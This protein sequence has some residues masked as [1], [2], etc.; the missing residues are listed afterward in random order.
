MSTERRKQAHAA[1]FA[2]VLALLIMLVIPLLKNSPIPSVLLGLAKSA[3]WST[4]YDRVN[5]LSLRLPPDWT[6]VDERLGL[7]EHD[8][9][10][11]IR[12]RCASLRVDRFGSAS[13]LAWFNPQGAF[14]FHTEGRWPDVMLNSADAYVGL[15]AGRAYDYLRYNNYCEGVVGGCPLLTRTYLFRHGDSLFVI[16]YVERAP[17][18]AE[19]QA[20]SAWKF[21]RTTETIISSIRF[22]DAH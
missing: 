5:G 4:H 6:Q 2:M 19:I 13:Q 12:N 18:Q 15:D 14:G 3:R 1:M 7:F 21:V 10:L 9:Q 8:C 22:P 20:P 17:H 11:P 16:T